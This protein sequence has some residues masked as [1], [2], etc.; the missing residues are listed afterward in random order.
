MSE[1]MDESRTKLISKCD[2]GRIKEMYRWMNE[3]INNELM[4]K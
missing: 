4:K 1:L 3:G 2:E